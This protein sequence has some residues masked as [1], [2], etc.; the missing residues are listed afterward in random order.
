[1]NPGGVLSLLALLI[2]LGSC[3]SSQGLSRDALEHV[4]VQDESRFVDTPKADGRSAQPNAPRLGLYLKP[5]GFV[6]REFEWTGGDR[7]T[8]LAWSQR[9]PNGAGGKNPG[10]L[11]P[12]SLKGDTLTELRATATRYGFDWLLVFDGAS[13]VDR[14]N[15]YKAPLLYWTILGA[16]LADGT[17][18]DSLC[19]LKAT[20]WD[21]KTGARLFEEHAEAKT[22]TVGPAALV[23]DLREIERAKATAMNLLLERLTNRFTA[24]STTPPRA[25]ITG[26]QRS[27]AVPTTRDVEMELTRSR[28]G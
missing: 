7:D 25:A 20:L 24:S 19:L 6:G 2:G 22:Q 21:V 18:S 23:D 11:T 15:N 9:L 14:Y 28:Q 16:Y 13:A 3:A 12:S 5:T 8:V 26:S 4:I 10:F 17:H 27:R 1:M